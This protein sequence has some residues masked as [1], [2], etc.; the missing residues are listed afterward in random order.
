MPGIAQRTAQG[1]GILLPSSVQTQVVI[2]AVGTGATAIDI[3]VATAIAYVSPNAD[4]VVSEFTIGAQQETAGVAVQFPNVVI[5][6]VSHPGAERL[7][8]NAVIFSLSRLNQRHRHR[9]NRQRIIIKYAKHAL[10]QHVEQHA[11]AGDQVRLNGRINFTGQLIERLARF[12]CAQQQHR[13]IQGQR[14]T[15]LR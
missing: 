7:P 4:T 8:P 14:R 11:T 10:I 9:W 13:V 12:R 3:I 15:A 1:E 5:T 6:A 2:I